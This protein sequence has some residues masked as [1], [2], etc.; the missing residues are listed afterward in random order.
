MFE[1]TTHV[2]EIGRRNTQVAGSL[3][4]GGFVC[5]TP[6]PCQSRDC[7]NFY[8]FNIRMVR[9]PQSGIEQLL[10]TLCW[11]MM[12][13]QELRHNPR[14]TYSAHYHEAHRMI[15]GAIDHVPQEL[16]RDRARYLSRAHRHPCPI[17]ASSSLVHSP[18]KHEQQAPLDDTPLRT[19]W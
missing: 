11:G 6:S 19:V 12:N 16:Q 15:I 9:T 5:L 10:N 8:T 1:S 7:S 2:A 13:H 14:M 18:P 4:D 17:N 3:L